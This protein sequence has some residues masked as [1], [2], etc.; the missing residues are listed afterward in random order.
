MGEDDKDI[1]SSQLGATLAL[2]ENGKVAIAY[3]N[4]DMD[5]RD[6]RCRKH[7]QG[8]GFHGGRKNFPPKSG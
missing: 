8:K 5:E 3:V 4:E 6:L 2:G 7:R 1:D